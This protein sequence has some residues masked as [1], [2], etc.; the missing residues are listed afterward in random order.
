[1]ATAI[2]VDRN[3]AFGLATNYSVVGGTTGVQWGTNA[4][5]P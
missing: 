4:G 3:S 5:T 1:V 2:L